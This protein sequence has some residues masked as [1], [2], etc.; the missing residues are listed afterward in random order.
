MSAGAADGGSDRDGGDVPHVALTGVDELDD[1][2]DASDDEAVPPR[3]AWEDL[4]PLS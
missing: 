3:R 1:E 2:E 4:P